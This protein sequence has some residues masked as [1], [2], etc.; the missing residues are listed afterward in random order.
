MTKI[1]C[2]WMNC[3]SNNDGK[4]DNKEMNRMFVN[5]KIYLQAGCLNYEFDQEKWMKK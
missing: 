4:C 2:L 1:T 3:K 5:R